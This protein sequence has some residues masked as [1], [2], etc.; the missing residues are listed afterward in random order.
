MVGYEVPPE[1]LE[2]YA[3]LHKN[4]LKQEHPGWDL[5]PAE[6]Q[7][8]FIND[9]ETD[10]D[11]ALLNNADSQGDIE[12]RKREQEFIRL[13]Q[14]SGGEPE[15]GFDIFWETI[16]KKWIKKHPEDTQE[17]PEA[18]KIEYARLI[19]EGKVHLNREKEA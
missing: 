13:V 10:E 17:S 15:K 16:R 2:L 7:Q 9:N 1:D 3:K 12:K 5:I 18:F 4:E 8:R 6:V 19:K 14:Q 11:W